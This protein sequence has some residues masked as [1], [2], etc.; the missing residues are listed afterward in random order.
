MNQPE[1]INELKHIVQPEELRLLSINR[2]SKILGI[3]NET[4]KNLVRT[5][6]I[7]AVTTTNH[8]FKIPYKCLLEY[9]NGN[10][11]SGVSENGIIPL[12]ETQSKIDSLIKEYSS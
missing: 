8:K 10:S 3:R 2:V 4:V 7:K 11:T 6:R 5:G 12:E 1:V 9:V